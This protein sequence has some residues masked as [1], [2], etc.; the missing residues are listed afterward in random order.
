MKKL[1]I[2][3]SKYADSAPTVVAKKTVT[4]AASMPSR[5]ADWAPFMSWES[6]S[7]PSGSVPSQ[8]R[9][10]GGAGCSL[11]STVSPGSGGAPV[12][13]GKRIASRVDISVFGSV[14]SFTTVLMSVVGNSSVP[15]TGS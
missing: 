15:T 4:T 13:V 11:T 2:H 14:T 12:S 5:N 10:S 8:W 9:P 3:P 6:T 1:S 7:R